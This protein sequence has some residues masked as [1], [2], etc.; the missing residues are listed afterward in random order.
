MDL[1]I[2]FSKDTQRTKKHVKKILNLNN[3][4]ENANQ[5]TPRYTKMAKIYKGQ[6]KCWQFPY[7]P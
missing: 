7:V 6:C 4:Q 2:H 1:K 3:N 5:T